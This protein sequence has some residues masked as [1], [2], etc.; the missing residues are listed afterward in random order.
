MANINTFIITYRYT[1][2]RGT[3]TVC[4]VEVEL[5]ANLTEKTTRELT[6]VNRTRNKL[7]PNSR[8]V[9][10]TNSQIVFFRNFSRRLYSV[11]CITDYFRNS[12]K[13]GSKFHQT[14][15]TFKTNQT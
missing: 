3:F 12:S 5:N 14:D 6:G 13:V 8:V 1:F 10:S 15:Y 2:V 7:F 4:S 11:V 9:Y